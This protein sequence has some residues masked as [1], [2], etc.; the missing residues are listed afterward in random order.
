MCFPK[1]NNSKP[2][3]G[4]PLRGHCISYLQKDVLCYT[5]ISEISVSFFF[6]NWPYIKLTKELK[7]S[8]ELWVVGQMVAEF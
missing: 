8:I 4:E 2:L 7:N 1:L 3:I 6:F 5:L